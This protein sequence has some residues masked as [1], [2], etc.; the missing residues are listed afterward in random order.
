[1]NETQKEIY[2]SVK[3]YIN[4]VFREVNSRNHTSTEWLDEH[5]CV[6]S[7]DV[8]YALEGAKLFVEEINRRLKV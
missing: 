6:H 2:K 8:G 5:G 3:Q 1:M 4:D 7:T